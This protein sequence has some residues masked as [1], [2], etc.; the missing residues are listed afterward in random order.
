MH[1]EI[2]TIE[3]SREKWASLTHFEA[4][5]RLTLTSQRLRAPKL[6]VLS[7]DHPSRNATQKSA[8][9]EKKTSFPLSLV[10]IIGIAFRIIWR[11]RACTKHC[12]IM[13]SKT[14]KCCGG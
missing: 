14:A 12:P 3:F 13:P 2:I 7:H 11:S 9:K 1:G 5:Y 6:F 4:R 8:Q 10:V